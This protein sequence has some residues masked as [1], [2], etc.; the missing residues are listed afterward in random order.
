MVRRDDES[1]KGS[2]LTGARKIVQDATRILQRDLGISEEEAYLTLQKQS[3][4]RRKSM[5]EIADAILLSDEIKGS[6]G[7]A[8]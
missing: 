8:G 6:Q 1:S 4:E 5:R 3:R 7:P 2:E